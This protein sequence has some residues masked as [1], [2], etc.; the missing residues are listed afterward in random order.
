VILVDVNLLV[1]A[2]MSQAPRH[3]AAR[4]WWHAQLVGSGRIALP[5]VSLTG[6][7]RVVGQSRI[8]T[9]PMP[10]GPALGAVRSWL[11]RPNVWIPEAGP[12]HLD[13]LDS[14]LVAA[15]AMEHGLTVC[16]RDGDFARWS[17]LGL[18]HR[19]PLR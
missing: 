1:E 9:H 5:W 11:S 16:S 18:R 3:G 13:L 4:P 19:D 12:Q 14:L 6:F 10:V 17:D 15:L 2:T 8:W 7:V